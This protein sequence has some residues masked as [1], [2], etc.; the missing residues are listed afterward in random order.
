VHAILVYRTARNPR[1]GP[2][3][4]RWFYAK[5]RQELRISMAAASNDF[6]LS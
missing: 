2:E 4:I 5:R 6:T 1:L 3:F